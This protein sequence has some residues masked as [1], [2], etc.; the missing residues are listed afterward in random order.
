MNKL[1]VFGLLLVLLAVLATAQETDDAMGQEL[2]GILFYL[3]VLLL[4]F[5]FTLV[6]AIPF[7][8]E[9]MGK[10]ELEVAKSPLSNH[11]V[12]AAE[13]VLGLYLVSATLQASGG[14]GFTET[15]KLVYAIAVICAM[16]PFVIFAVM[17]FI[18][19]IYK[20]NLLANSFS[21]LLWGLV[22][23]SA[24]LFLNNA[25]KSALPFFVVRPE[26][27][28]LV[29]AAFFEEAF[30]GIG[31]AE[32]IK[33][34]DVPVVRGM[35]YGF[36]IGVGFSMLENWLYFTYSV[37]PQTLGTPNWTQVLFYRSF[38]TTMAHGLFTAAN[39]FVVCSM[40]KSNARF[41]IGLLFAFVLH[42][43]YNVL[44]SGSSIL[45]PLLVLAMCAGFL[46]VAY[47][48][49]KGEERRRAHN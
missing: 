10:K 14:R 20:R 3:G 19:N 44:V 23:G 32:F 40:S 30:K 48:A 27:V 46:C 37:S 16:L 22:S 26:V 45:G 8:E 13:A 43:L 42:L 9:V 7:I 28:F 5:L 29:L 47:S 49:M 6:V 2:F 24:A 34:K 39:A 11:F 31:L 12:W 18:S 36:A 1:V 4:T 25:M 21:M 35:L 17:A 38:F 33:T 15:E 41:V